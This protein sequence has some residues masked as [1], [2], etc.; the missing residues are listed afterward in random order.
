MPDPAKENFLLGEY[1]FSDRARDVQRHC[2]NARVQQNQ[3]DRNR[4]AGKKPATLDLR[5]DTGQAAEPVNVE[6]LATTVD[7]ITIT[8]PS[9]AWT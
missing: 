2:G 9:T 1:R 7:A 6:A 5:L 3:Q 8:S 4:L